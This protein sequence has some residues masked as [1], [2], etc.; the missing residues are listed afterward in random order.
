[1]TGHGGGHASG[2]GRRGATEFPTGWSREQITERLLDVARYPDETPRLLAN[3]LWHTTGVREDVRIVVLLEAAG[4]VRTAFPVEG[5]GVVRNPD[6]ATDPDH[7]TLD[8]LAA[9][10][11]SYETSERL[12]SVRERLSDADRELYEQ[13]HRAGEWDELDALLTAEFGAPTP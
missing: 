8:D 9:G 10:R 12:A 6:R 13:L 3:G 1:M 5:P 11:A 2:T 4:S 7:P